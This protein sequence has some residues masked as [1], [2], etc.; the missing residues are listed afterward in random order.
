MNKPCG[1]SIDDR[2]NSLIIYGKADALKQIG[3][4]LTQIDSPDADANVEA[5]ASAV[6]GDDARSVLLRIFWLADG[7][8]DDEGQA[9]DD[10]LRPSSG[11]PP[12]TQRGSLPSRLRAK[13]GL[14]VQL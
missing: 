13:I 14:S 5:A 3:E 2:T 10:F 9:P 11:R 1:A 6:R 12:L 4:L 8:P 7:L